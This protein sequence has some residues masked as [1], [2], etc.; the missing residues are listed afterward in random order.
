MKKMIKGCGCVVA[1]LVVATIALLAW[2]Y[3]SGGAEQQTFFAAVQSG[4]PSNMTALMHPKLK[5]QIDEPVLGAWMAAFNTHLGNFVG[6]DTTDFNTESKIENGVTI[7][8][9]KGTVK[10]DKG[11]AKSDLVLHNGLII[12]FNVQSDKLANVNWL[13][14]IPDT[15]LYRDRGKECLTML[16]TG[17]ADDAFPKFHESTQKSLPLAKMKAMMANIAT[18]AGPLESVTYLSES[19]QPGKV[20]ELNVFYNVVCQKGKTISS[21]TFQFTGWQSHMTGFDLQAVAPGVAP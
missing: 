13:T 9:S 15:T 21:V 11:T 7:K 2:A 6:L 19:F 3:I 12:E 17:K 10:F 5:E 18:Q 14:K 8:T 16:L 4:N 1:I 20:P